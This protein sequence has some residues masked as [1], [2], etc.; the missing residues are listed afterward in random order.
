MGE[1]HWENYETV[2]T[3]ICN[4]GSGILALGQKPRNKLVIFAETRAEWM[5]AAQACFKYNFPGEFFFQSSH[6]FFLS[7]LPSCVFFCFFS[8][9][10]LSDGC[11]SSS[12]SFNLAQFSDEG[13]TVKW[14]LWKGA[15]LCGNYS[16]HTV[17]SPTQD[18]PDGRPPLFWDRLFCLGFVLLCAWTPEKRPPFF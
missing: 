17:Q 9:S 18:Q 7:A 10:P 6:F 8:L 3:R 12:V 2:F 14:R 1:Y 11:R 4:F 13:F 5:I 15:L 16:A